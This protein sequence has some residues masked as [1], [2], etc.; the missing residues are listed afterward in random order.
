MP[1]PELSTID[2]ISASMSIS[3]L[4]NQVIASNIANHDTPGYRRL[5]LAFGAALDGPAAA[6]VV[7][8]APETSAGATLEQDLVALS[9]NATHYQALAR[10]LSRWFAI[11]NTITGSK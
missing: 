10:V 11:A 6:A 9:T 8:E 1:V 5:A 7:P 4:R 2:R 3:S